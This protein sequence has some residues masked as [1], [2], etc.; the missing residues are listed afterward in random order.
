[1]A[2]APTHLTLPIRPYRLAA[3]LDVRIVKLTLLIERLT[4]QAETAAA[5]DLQRRRAQAAESGAFVGSGEILARGRL[6]RL[7]R[8]VDGLQIVASLAHEAQDPLVVTINDLINLGLL[9]APTTFQD[10]GED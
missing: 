9:Q 2:D 5:D 6:A 10:D 3:L 1:M 7:R 8:T 4:T